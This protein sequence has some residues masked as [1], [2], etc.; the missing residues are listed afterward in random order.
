MRDDAPVLIWT[1]RRCG[2][3]NLSRLV[4]EAAGRPVASDE[5]FNPNRAYGYVKKRWLREGDDEQ[6]KKD[7]D[8]ILSKRES[9]KH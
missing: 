1:F 7:L 5:P 2:G 6:L 9:F 4:F 8:A 3:S